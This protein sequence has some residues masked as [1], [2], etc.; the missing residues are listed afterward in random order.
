[1]IE[2]SL[3]FLAWLSVLFIQALVHIKVVYL[4]KVR[5][6]DEPR[7]IERDSSISSEPMWPSE[8][9]TKDE[10]R[11]IS[12]LSRDPAMDNFDDELEFDFYDE[13][14]NLKH[15][16]SQ[17]GSEMMNVSYSVEVPLITAVISANLACLLL[18]EL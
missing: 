10:I 1:M 7:M 17:T 5:D 11:R 3:S 15:R 6:D 18:S 16:L 8:T 2:V 12:L 14:P 4:R 9:E 13:P